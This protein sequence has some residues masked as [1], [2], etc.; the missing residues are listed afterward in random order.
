[1][2]SSTFANSFSGVPAASVEGRDQGQKELASV[3]CPIYIYIY[4]FFSNDSV[5]VTDIVGVSP[6]YL[7]QPCWWIR[8]FFLICLPDC[9]WQQDTTWQ[10]TLPPAAAANYYLILHTKSQPWDF[11][12]GPVVKI[13]S[14][15]CREHRLDPWWGN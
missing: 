5:I 8:I 7:Y 13:S 1:M 3:G 12:G 11:P 6:R 4:F 14:F 9:S 2:K 15:H 10:V